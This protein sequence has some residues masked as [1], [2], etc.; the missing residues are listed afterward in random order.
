[1]YYRWRNLAECLAET[2]QDLV[3]ES[4]ELKTCQK[5]VI[6]L[7]Q[8]LQTLDSTERKLSQSCSTVHQLKVEKKQIA[9]QLK[10]AVGDI[11]E[12]EMS[13]RELK[14]SLVSR[15]KLEEER[16]KFIHSTEVSK[17]TLEKSKS[18]LVIQARDDKIKILESEIDS[19]KSKAKQ[20]DNIASS[21][22]K[23]LISMNAFNERGFVRCVY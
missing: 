3:N 23:S 5:E 22:I 8:K 16:T 4:R 21:G 19:L 10:R 18:E 7:E 13:K 6:F 15:A 20:Y 14:D 11:K 17:L 9:D 12:V 1:M 2:K